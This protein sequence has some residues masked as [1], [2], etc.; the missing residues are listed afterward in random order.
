MKA[1]TDASGRRIFYN[2]TIEMPSLQDFG[3]KTNI[4][5]IFHSPCNIVTFRKN[6][7]VFFLNRTFNFSIIKQ[8]LNF[9]R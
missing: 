7:V 4:W 3:V 2:L 1:R 6:T 8:V 9:A 5:R